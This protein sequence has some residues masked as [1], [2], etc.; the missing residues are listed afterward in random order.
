MGRPVEI[1]QEVDSDDEDE[2]EEDG[3]FQVKYRSPAD[4][5]TDL[6][7]LQQKPLFISDL[8]QG[9]RSDDHQRFSIALFSAEGLIRG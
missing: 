2:G 5:Y 3:D 1:K 4:D 6:T 8:L 7:K 9:L